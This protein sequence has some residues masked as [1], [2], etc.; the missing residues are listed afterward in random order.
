[1]DALFSQDTGSSTSL[2]SSSLEQISSEL[3]GFFSAPN[4]ANKLH[5][6][7]DITDL[8]ALQALIKAG[9]AGKLELPGVEVLPSQNMGEAYG[10]YSAAENKIYL[11]DSLLDN[12][13]AL[14][15]VLQEEVGHSF[16][17]ILNPS[18][19]SAGDEGELFQNIIAGYTLEP[20][21]LA[22][23][24]AENDFGTITN[25]HGVEIAVELDN[26]I[27][28]AHN[29]G[30]LAGSI[31]YT[32][33]V[34]ISDRNDYYRFS[35]STTSNFNLSLNTLSADADVQLLNAAGDPIAISQRSG[36]SPENINRS[37]TPGTY[38]VRVYPYQRANTNYRLILSAT[39]VTPVD[40]Y[41][42][43][44]TAIPLG[45]LSGRRS[46]NNSIGGTDTNDYYRFSV[47]TF[48]R[49]NLSLTG[50]SADADVQL[51]N[52]GGRVIAISQRAGSSRESIS[53]SLTRG[54]YYVR[55]Y[56]YQDAD[57]DYRL[58]LSAF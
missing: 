29:F 45:D 5:Q 33:Y 40:D 50:L 46:F 30:I 17:P 47:N 32:D 48:R 31:G 18:G 36:S 9:S 10:A 57:T 14:L 24:K 26:S 34:G 55:V 22:A 41:P 16:D 11:S 37:L 53:R 39:P 56:P 7:Y 28:R 54:T 43:R 4:A 2:I 51:Q 1:M 38:Y 20:S 12:S 8:G 6:I 15:N 52:A 27:F 58:T 23:I 13:T 35:I 19:D 49:F 3:E 21:Q 42:S 25:S 44:Q